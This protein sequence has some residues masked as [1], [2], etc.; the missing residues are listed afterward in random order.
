M[1]TITIKN[2]SIL[3]GQTSCILRHVYETQVAKLSDE[4]KSYIGIQLPRG[5]CIVC[6][7]QGNFGIP[8]LDVIPYGYA[9]L[10]RMERAVGLCFEIEVPQSVKIEN[11]PLFSGIE[12]EQD[13]GLHGN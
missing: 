3:H 8:F 5:T 2:A 4:L 1:S 6:L 12:Q 9:K 13:G 7:Y 11:L 10:M